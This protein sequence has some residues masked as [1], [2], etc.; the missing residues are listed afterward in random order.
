M[1]TPPYQALILNQRPSLYWRLGTGGAGDLSPNGNNGTAAGGITIGGATGAISGDADKA[2]TFDG[3][4]DQIT[5]GYSPFVAANQ[6]TLIGWANRANTAANHTIFGGDG[7][8]A[9]PRLRLVSGSQDVNWRYDSS[10]GVVTTWTAAWP[11]TGVWVHWALVLDTAAGTVALYINGALVSQQAN[12]SAYSTPGNLKLGTFQNAI[13]DPF[14]GSQDEVAVFDRALTPAEIL[15]QY[16]AGAPGLVTLDPTLSPPVRVTSQ[17]ADGT[18]Y[19]LTSLITSL[20]YSNVNP[21]GD[22]AASFT[23]TKQWTTAIP[24][25]NRGNILRIM[26]GLD[27]VWQGRIEEADRSA[28]QT[29]TVN[30]TAYGLGTR[31]RDSTM[32]EIY[33]DRDISRW[34]DMSRAQ[35]I[36]FLSGGTYSVGNFEQVFDT[37]SGLPAL[38]TGVTGAWAATARPIGYALYDAGP[39]LIA[40]TIYVDPQY[41]GPV[42]DGTWNVKVN[43]A[44]TDTPTNESTVSSFPTAGY[45]TIG[46]RVVDLQ[47]FFNAAGGTEGLEQLVMWRN[48]TV[49]GNHGLTRQGSDPGGFT[50]DQI[51]RNVLGRASGITARRI[52]SQTFVIPHFAVHDPTPHQDVIESAAGV[53]LV[54]WGTWGP[55]SPLDNSTTG[56]F[57]LTT[58]DR[59]TAHWFA[60]RFESDSLDLHSETATLYNRVDVAY[61][62][63]SGTSFLETR[64]ASVPELDQA[65]ITRTYPL[66]GGLMTQAGAQTYGDTFLSLFGGFAPARGSI[67]YSRPIIHYRRGRISPLYMRADG[68]NLRVPDVLP[69]QTLFAL[70]SSPDRRTM[71]PIKRVSVDLSSGAVPQAQVDLDQA[72]DA[73]SALGARLAL[74]AQ[75]NRGYTLPASSQPSRQPQRP[76]PWRARWL[77]QHNHPHRPP[78]R[79]HTETLHNAPH[80]HRHRH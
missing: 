63:A 62:D 32:R 58:Q 8:A 9:S 68:S 46:S 69:T 53:V 64:T 16:K 72:S 54:D 10:T 37:G 52:D 71:F 57:D 66:D 40:A 13:T 11:G 42:N 20:S 23:Y 14:N 19:D 39:S 5:S 50:T 38:K 30:V 44:D 22:E 67:S 3:V 55:S 31:L 76:D 28:D 1:S 78:H 61:Q 70:D 17:S 25:L 24:E 59:Q 75:Y 74:E 73:L 27:V 7:S 2:T 51:V 34:G 4:D 48:P 79:R 41:Q 49:Y 35:Q 33:V 60:Y 77:W 26:A 21:G 15:A 18:T 36:A 80:H 43:K 56:Y 45:I 6:R 29:E 65:G 12:A 47:V